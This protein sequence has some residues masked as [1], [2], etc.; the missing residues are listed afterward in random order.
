M[1]HR[2]GYC[3]RYSG[4]YLFPQEEGVAKEKSKGDVICSHCSEQFLDF[5]V[6]HSPVL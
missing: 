4:G 5:S 1:V 2:S 3:N 6:V